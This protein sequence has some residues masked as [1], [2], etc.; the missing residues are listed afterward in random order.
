LAG[1]LRFP[2]SRVQGIVSLILFA[3]LLV[4]PPTLLLVYPQQGIALF[5]AFYRSGALVFGG[6]HVVLPLLQAQVVNPG[7]TDNQTFLAG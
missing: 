5:D 6:G 2:V 4:A 1:K 7:W 3:V